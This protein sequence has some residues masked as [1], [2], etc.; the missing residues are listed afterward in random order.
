MEKVVKI[1]K[2][3]KPV[4]YKFNGTYCQN[5]GKSFSD[6]ETILSGIFCSECS[7]K[8][9]RDLKIDKE[10]KVYYVQYHTACVN[11]AKPFT[12]QDNNQTLFGMYCKSCGKKW[13]KERKL[14]QARLKKA[15]GL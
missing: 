10:A 9:E 8:K 1:R 14:R 15:R 4:W 6:M 3:T 12:T 7:P 5:C 2:N 11:C 13:E